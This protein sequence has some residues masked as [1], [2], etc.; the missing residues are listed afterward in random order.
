[1]LYLCWFLLLAHT[2][3]QGVRM[4]PSKLV[5]TEDIPWEHG[6]CMLFSGQT[7]E[8][9]ETSCCCLPPGSAGLCMCDRWI[10]LEMLLFAFCAGLLWRSDVRPSV[11]VLVVTHLVKAALQWVCVF[12]ACAC[13]CVSLKPC[14]LRHGSFC[15]QPCR[16]AKNQLSV[17]FT[18]FFSFVARYSLYK[19]LTELTSFFRPRLVDWTVCFFCYPRW[20]NLFALWH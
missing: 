16:T 14:A 8:V 13:V 11:M 15:T 12:C 3:E 20:K 19:L 10:D 2:D 4:A 6:A 18:L 1:M 5:W 9:K 7:A 17:C